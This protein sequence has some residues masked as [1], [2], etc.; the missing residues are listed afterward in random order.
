M[1][2]GESGVRWVDEDG[3]TAAETRFPEPLFRPV[4]VPRDPG[5]AAVVGFSKPKHV[6]AFDVR[7]TR[8]LDLKGK[9]YKLPLVGDVIGDGEPEVLVPEGDGFRIVGLDGTR[10]GEVKAPW[11]ASDRTLV[12]ADGDPALEIAFVKTH[13]SGQGVQVRIVNADGSLVSAWDS[14]EGN[15][16]SWEPALGDELLWGVTPQG[17]S[18]W[19]ARGVPRETYPAPGVDYLRYVA[20]ARSTDYLL[21]AA[22]GGGYTSLGTICIYSRAGALV[23][24][25]VY[26]AR[27]YAVLHD[28]PTGAFYVGA[29]TDL[30]R[31]RP[32]PSAGGAR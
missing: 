23:Y 2:V 1:I 9:S 10:R 24:Q 3:R 13:L 16:L 7:G 19:S 25:E 5:G 29:G 31:Y 4:L 8:L 18:A 20:G 17:F 30:I 32:V 14:A 6:R 26:G 12:Q 11:Y 22:S 27:T 15:W 28:A 21:L